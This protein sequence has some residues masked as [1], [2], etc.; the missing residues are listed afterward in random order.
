MSIYHWLVILLL[1][2]AVFMRGDL[3]GNKQYIVLAMLLMFCVHSLRDGATI[4]NDSRTSYR[5]QYIRMGETEWQD[6][7]GLDDWRDS[8]TDDTRSNRERNIALPWLMKL[9]YQL[10]DGNYQWFLAVVAAIVLSA[11]AITIQRYSPSPVLSILFYLGLLY[12]VMELSVFKQSI[13]MSFVLLSFTSIMERRPIRFVI[14]ILIGSLFHFP[15]LVF[16]PAYWIANMKIS[17]DY[18]LILAGLFIVTYLFRDRLVDLMTD[19]YDT[20][21]QSVANKRFL[22][23]KVIIML[24]IIVT[25][26]IVR[27]PDPEDRVY[28]AILQL[29]GI[30]A[31]IQTFA[32][33]NNTFERLAD[34]Y[35][36]FAIIFIPMVF[37]RVDTKRAVFSANTLDL[38]H[39]YGPFVFGAFAIW[40]FLNNIVNDWHYY[41]FRFFWQ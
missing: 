23:N 18:L 26:L 4:G 37:E 2:L 6:L 24:I 30:A 5:W 19:S 10:S 35:F 38:V 31:V 41:P 15:A 17:R 8:F 28:C 12:F 7:R 40:R 32:S 20:E 34:Y 14:L 13:A 39:S 29:L 22:A 36:Q 11:L 33:Y 1:L 9:V 27:P 21:I 3:K 25:A 16:L